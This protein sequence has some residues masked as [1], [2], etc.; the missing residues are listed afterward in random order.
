MSYEYNEEF[1]VKINNFETSI[2]ISVDVEM[3][4]PG[5]PETGPSMS[6][7]GEPG[8]GPTFECGEIY[9]GV[10][11]KIYKLPSPL[12]TMLFGDDEALAFLERAEQKASENWEE[13]EPDYPDYDDDAI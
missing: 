5:Y 1:E 6:G 4:S 2:Y 9:V 12:F 10:E 3:I 7:P 11:G 13:E 8:E